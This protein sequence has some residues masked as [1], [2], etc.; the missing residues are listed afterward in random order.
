MCSLTSYFTTTNTATIIFS[1]KFY[2]ANLL[3]YRKIL[4]GRYPI[5]LKKIRINLK[6]IRINLKK[7]RIKFKKLYHF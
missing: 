1:R 7:I 2:T 4:N 3:G 6:K 5:D